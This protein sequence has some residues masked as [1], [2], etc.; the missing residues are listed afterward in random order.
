MFT[1]YIPI[2]QCLSVYNIFIIT[3]VKCSSQWWVMNWKECGMKPTRP[4]IRQYPG[5]FLEKWKKNT[6]NN[7]I[8]WLRTGSW[9]HAK[10]LAMGFVYCVVSVKKNVM[11]E[12]IRISQFDWCSSQQCKVALRRYFIKPLKERSCYTVRQTAWTSHFCL[13]HSFYEQFLERKR[14]VWT[15]TATRNKKKIS[16][17][18]DKLD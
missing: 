12:Y 2:E 6:K 10:N 13:H 16:S 5:T 8:I 1:L 4:N 15:L 3:N 14:K 11:R 9:T 7:R 17:V 18:Q